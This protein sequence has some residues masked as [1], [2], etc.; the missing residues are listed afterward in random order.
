MNFKKGYILSKGKLCE[1]LKQVHL[2]KTS[3]EIC[4]GFLPQSSLYFSFG[5]ESEENGKDDAKKENNFI[6][7]IQHI[8]NVVQEQLDKS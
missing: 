5:V 4:L 7:R 6:Q 2:I 1:L 8:H 3:F